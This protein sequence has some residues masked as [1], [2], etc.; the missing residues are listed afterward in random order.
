MKLTVKTPFQTPGVCQRLDVTF[1][2]LDGFYPCYDNTMRL[3]IVAFA[4]LFTISHSQSLPQSAREYLRQGNSTVIQALLANP[5]PFMDQ[6]LWRDAINYGLAA[7]DAAPANPEPYGYLGKVYNYVNFHDAAWDAYQSFRAFGGTPDERQRQQIVELGRTLG[8]E[9]FARDDFATALEYY[10]V[11]Y[12]YAPDDQELNLQIARSYLGNNRADLASAYLRKLD[13]QHLG[14]YGRYLETASDQ[15]TYGQSASDAYERGIKQYYLG[16]LSEARDSF[17]Q[18]ARLDPGFQKAFVWAGRVSLELSQPELALPYWQQAQLLQPNSADMQYFL[19]LTQNQLRWGVPA[20]TSFEQGM[21]FYN[22]GKMSEARGRLEQAL[23]QNPNF[24]EAWAW[25]G[26]IA[27][28][29]ADY[30]TSYEAFSK[31]NQL[32]SN[33]TY[34]Y[35]KDAS[36]RQLG[37]NTNVVASNP[38]NLEQVAPVQEVK[39]LETITASPVADEAPVEAEITEAEITEAETAV[40]PTSVEENPFTE[41]EPATEVK[42]VGVDINSVDINSIDSNV[43]EPNAQ[44]NPVIE[45]VS[46]EPSVNEAADLSA[47]VNPARVAADEVAVTNVTPQEDASFS[48]TSTPDPSTLIE[49]DLRGI[50]STDPLVLLSTYYTYERSDI[51]STGAVSF[52]AATSDIQM[53]WQTPTNY[54]EGV[55]Y[56]RLEVSRK[57]ST[58]TVTYQLCLVPNDDIAIKPACSRAGG[59]E[60][61]DIGVYTSQQ[62]IKEFY[63]YDNI[64][65]SRGISNL[66]VIL[67]DKNG[68]PVD[69]VFSKERK[70]NLDLYYPMEVRYSVVIVPKGGA[71]QGWP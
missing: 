32:T 10:L 31:A 35:F 59:L 57:P 46:V 17:A 63:Q 21:V 15:L 64:N 44:V 62:P 54:A 11:A 26:R 36:A 12:H 1:S 18:A 29:G 25:L 9:F 22:Q 43:A 19:A 42:P 49:N 51:E 52:F 30:Q 3:L 13:A 34:I 68:N 55:V 28:E 24:S 50:T 40:V 69:T 16:N 48:D 7:K 38:A 33:E 6:P 39:R 37:I 23:T 70:Q 4:L 27:Y 41:V 5:H 56:Q 60:F 66:M 14:D 58:E 71:F 53:D 67:R 47:Q 8:Y 45:A 20:Y 2:V 65:W 61:S